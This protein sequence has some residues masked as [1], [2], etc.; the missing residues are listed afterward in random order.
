M[1]S[2][3]PTMDLDIAEFLLQ[4]FQTAPLT[5]RLLSDYKEGKAYSYF[6]SK[7]LDQVLYHPL[8]EESPVCIMKSKSTPSQK[9]NHVP[10]VIW[11]AIEKQSGS[12]KSSY[13]TCFAG[14]VSFDLN[15]CIL[16]SNFNLMFLLC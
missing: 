14:Y 10:H 13:C 2:W 9:I 4:N 11:I 12:I 8:D 1:S 15:F 16:T 3:P 5:K 7:W 6:D